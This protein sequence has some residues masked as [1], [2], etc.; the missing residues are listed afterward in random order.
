MASPLSHEWTPYPARGEEAGLPRG[1]TLATGLPELDRLLKGG[2]PR[3]KLV[4]VTGG[5]SSGKT[6]LISSILRGASA[7]GECMAYV[8]AFDTLDP[9]SFGKAGVDPAALLWVRCR[10]TGLG[11]E[12]AAER[13]LKAADILVQAGGFGVVVLDLDPVEYRHSS[14]ILRISAHTWFRLQR[15]VKGSPTILLVLSGQKLTGTAAAVV[16]ALE[17]RQVHWGTPWAAYR[18]EDCTPPMPAGRKGTRFQGVDSQARL[19]KGEFHGCIS[20]HCRF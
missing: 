13:A 15:A 11:P 3:G 5:I 17:R 6:S 16:L 14:R 18:F 9:E 8:D 2:F 4:E 12:A 20:V 7:A 19:L 1:A 10:A